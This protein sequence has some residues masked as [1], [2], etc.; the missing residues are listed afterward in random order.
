VIARP[1]RM[2]RRQ[3]EVFIAAARRRPRSG[4]AG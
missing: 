2:H 4:Q 1:H 3:R